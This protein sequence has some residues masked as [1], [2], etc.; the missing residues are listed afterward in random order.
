[1]KQDQAFQQI[2]PEL[3][4]LA[5]AQMAN[6]RPSHTLTPTALVHDAYVRLAQRGDVSYADKQH[7]FRVAANAMRQV[8][9]DHAR[10]KGRVKR[11]G[12]FR[13]L[14]IEDVDIAAPLERREFDTD[15]LLA[16]AEALETLDEQDPQ[17]ARVVD[18]RYFSGATMG[19]IATTLGVAER[20]VY[21]DW[22][23]ARA[24][25]RGLL[26]Q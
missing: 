25:L 21:N 22:S 17:L 10:G 11:G 2:Y 14:G 9:I 5:N 20:T 24:K 16:L 23:A 7:F 3:K 4:A 15:D 26:P 1:M 13:R 19:D 18:L 6:E 8:L 12:A